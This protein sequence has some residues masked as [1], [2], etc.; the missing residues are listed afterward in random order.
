[1]CVK[2]NKFFKYRIDTSIKLVFVFSVFNI[3]SCIFLPFY[4]VPDFKY[5][6][7]LS[8]YTLFSV[9][10]NVDYIAKYSLFDSYSNFTYDKNIISTIEYILYLIVIINIILFTVYFILSLKYREKINIFSKIVYF[11]SLFIPVF[12]MIVCVYFNV[13]MNNALGVQNNFL[14]LTLYSKMQPSI[15]PVIQLIISF[16]NIFFSERIL[17]RKSDNVLRNN[18]RQIKEKTTFNKKTKISLLIIFILIPIVILFGV[19]VL[20]DRNFYFIS[21]CIIA[22]IMIPFFLIFEN[23]KPQAREIIIIVVLVVI[24]VMGR[25]A[26][27]MLPNFKPVTAI[28][29][30]AGIS[31]GA[32]AGFLTG[33]LVALISNFFFGQGPWTPWQMFAFGVIGFLSG[34]IFVN[35]MEKIVYNKAV[36]CS[37]GFIMAFIVYG[38]IMDTSSVLSYM[39]GI[40]IQSALTKYVSGIS[41]NLSHG[42]S[43]MIFLYFIYKP[44]IKKINR[45]KLKYG[46]L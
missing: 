42:I 18:T 9:F 16:V 45:V 28:V 38:F 39:D 1:M 2:M 19:F 34:V 12:S 29:I 21:L 24:A 5:L 43:T 26:F 3:V 6:K 40:T 46:I 23:R 4:Y 33:A 32:Q 41:V 27:S 25:T 13:C 37:Y 7:K 36:I 10:D 44:M 11:Y 22:L 31:L 20:K 35:N 30:I 17:Y 8:Y 14:N 15:V